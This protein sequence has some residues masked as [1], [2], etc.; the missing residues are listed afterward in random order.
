MGFSHADNRD[1]NL[2]LSGGKFLPSIVT[3]DK[4]GTHYYNQETK[5]QSMEYHYKSF[6]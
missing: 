5:H 3:A 1:E 4:T 6:T 2:L